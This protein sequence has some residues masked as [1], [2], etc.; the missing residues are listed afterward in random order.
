MRVEVLG[1]DRLLRLVLQHAAAGAAPRLV[2]DA[3]VHVQRFIARALAVQRALELRL[4]RA[5][6]EQ[7]G[8]ERGRQRQRRA[9]RKP[10]AR[11]QQQ[12]QRRTHSDV[13]AG[14]VL[15]SLLKP[16][17]TYDDIPNPPPIP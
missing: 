16:D 2:A 9:D 11:Q 4:A 10:H 13:G 8:L 17:M 5:A 7:L 3:D 15:L 6:A 14:G 1:R 12:D